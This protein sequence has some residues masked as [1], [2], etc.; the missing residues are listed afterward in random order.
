MDNLLFTEVQRRQHPTEYFFARI[1]SCS[2]AWVF[3]ARLLFKE[4]LSAVFLAFMIAPSFRVEIYSF[5]QKSEKETTQKIN[6]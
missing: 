6:K 3:P 5:S 4:M 1:H 2:A